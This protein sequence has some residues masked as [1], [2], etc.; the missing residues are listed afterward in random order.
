MDSTEFGGG[1]NY[2]FYNSAASTNT[3]IGFGGVN[4]GVGSGTISSSLYDST[5][6]STTTKNVK[7]TNSFFSLGAGVKYILNNGF[8][9]R[10]LFDFYKTN[11]TLTN[12]TENDSISKSSLAGTRIHFGISYRF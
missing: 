10:A 1:A 6:E 3:L 8:G 9:I 7:M 12:T 11:Q 5:T 2:H 4:F